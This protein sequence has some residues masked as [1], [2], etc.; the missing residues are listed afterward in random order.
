MWGAGIAGGLVGGV[1]MGVILHGGANLMP[2]IGALYGWPTVFG[3]WITHLLNSVLLGVLFAVVVSLPFFREQT[4]SLE[5]CILA[6]IVY[7]AAIALV[8][9][10]IMLPLTMNLL[11]IKVLPESLVPVPG[12]IGGILVVVSVG[13]AHLV[14]GLLLGAIYGVLH[15]TPRPDEH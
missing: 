1:G 6:G 9:S 15:N 3:G 13:V 7:A 12:V 8:T 14:Y 5:G 10:G 11:D 2:F 4:T